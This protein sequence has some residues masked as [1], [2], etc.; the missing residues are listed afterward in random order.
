M[1]MRAA[2]MQELV[3]REYRRF[4]SWPRIVKAAIQGAFTRF[5]T[6]TE[7]QRAR[8]R[9]LPAGKRFAR[10]LRIHSEYKFTPAIFLAM[11]RRRLHDMIADPAYRDFLVRLQSTQAS[12]HVHTG[13][14]EM[15][16]TAMSH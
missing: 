4:Y 15:S 12:E 1:Q 2:E 16:E 3:E 6:F 10:W 8:L 14:S 9:E 13:E 7:P 11:G 5:R